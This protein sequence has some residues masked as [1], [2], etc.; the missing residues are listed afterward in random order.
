MN[1]FQGLND[2]LVRAFTVFWK[3]IRAVY[4]DLFQF[5]WM[6]MLWWL[7]T[8]TVILAPAVHM[9]LNRV[10]YRVATYRR[11]DNDFFYTGVRMNV[12]EAYLS[13]G[14]NLVAA[15]VL[16]VCIWFYANVELAWVNLMVIPLFWIAVFFMLLTQFVFPLVWEQDERSLRLTYKNAM[17][18]VLRYPFFCL[19]VFLLKSAALILFS[20][21]AGIPLFFF[22]P[23]L[24]TT[25][26]NYA[27]NYLLQD[28]GLAPPPP[29]FNHPR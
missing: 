5:V 17:I 15:I 22:G 28:M 6:S 7:G 16:V 12:R 25:I 20:L 13:Y 18:L 21:P 26:S 14:L 10:S 29:D 1:F 8:A 3:S 23:A 11:I 27:L 4:D 2:S 24:S 9:G 19:L